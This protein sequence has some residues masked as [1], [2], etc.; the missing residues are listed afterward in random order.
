MTCV[1]ISVV[2]VIVICI[3][4]LIKLCLQSNRGIPYS[5]ETWQLLPSAKC[6]GNSVGASVSDIN[7]NALSWA[8]FYNIISGSTRNGGQGLNIG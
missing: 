1:I 5:L 4:C 7:K 3:S 6:C 8:A 2:I